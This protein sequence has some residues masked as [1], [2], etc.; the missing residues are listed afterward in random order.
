MASPN[1]VD[2]LLPT[3]TRPEDKKDGREKHEKERDAELGHDNR[4]DKR[5]QRKPKPSLRG[6][7]GP[8][9][10][11]RTI[12]LPK[13]GLGRKPD[14]G[15][16]NDGDQ[17]HGHRYRHL[18]RR[19]FPYDIDCTRGEVQGHSAKAIMAPRCWA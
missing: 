16:K 18:A 10:A 14:A 15:D 7:R 12:R 17:K 8:I 13:A 9:Q 19:C 6:K 2:V 3:R 11:P 1:P 4:K 5:A